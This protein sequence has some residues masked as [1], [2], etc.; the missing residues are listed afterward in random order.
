MVALEVAS[1]RMISYL[2][3][4]AI[5]MTDGI[6]YDWAG[7]SDDWTTPVGQ[8]ESISVACTTGGLDATAKRTGYRTLS[9]SLVANNCSNSRLTAS[10]T[11][12]FTYNDDYFYQ[13]TPLQFY[14]LR[15]TFSN[16]TIRDTI[17]RSFTYSGSLSCDYAYNSV[18]ES[19]KETIETIDG[20]NT[21]VIEVSWGS[22]YDDPDNQFDY[23]NLVR[24]SDGSTGTY[25]VG[26][27]N[28]DFSNVTAREGNQYHTIVNAKYID[29]D[30][31][32]YDPSFVISEHDR[33]ERLALAQNNTVFAR[34]E[35]NLDNGSSSAT[36]STFYSGKTVIRHAVEGDLF[37]DTSSASPV[38]NYYA[39]SGQYSTGN[40]QEVVQF[41]YFAAV[42][43]DTVTDRLS[44]PNYF[45]DIS[46]P[47]DFDN[48]G[49][50]DNTQ[51]YPWV[52]TAFGAAETCLNRLVRFADITVVSQTQSSASGCVPEGGFLLNDDGTV[53]YQD[54][55]LDGVNELFTLDDDGDGV[56]D[57]EDTFPND[58][59]ESVDSDGDGIGDN[60]DPY[61]NNP[62]AFSDSD[63]DGV[64]DNLDAFPFDASESVD[65]D[66][67]G[68]GNN[69]DNDDDN[70]GVID[71]EDAL[72]LDSLE[73]KILNHSL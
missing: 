23:E 38:Y 46:L 59:S 44:S 45:Y 31:G 62:L 43:L 12:E 64:S 4:L 21:F 8:S 18:S 20:A 35:L 29:G 25:T 53:Y 63:G 7:E 22:L 50:R 66:G 65:S 55:N 69:G 30:S 68:V 72:P 56:Q 49:E 67:D 47:V 51:G 52:Y 39:Y 57:S 5:G 37:L 2:G 40:Y 14:P 48:D 17:G 70:D 1:H 19:Y 58:P 15:Y 73:T 6:I 9:G 34:V 32:T 33:S 71:S 16:L 36:E 13:D 60:A 26:Y 61:P 24:N 41:D 27:T 3:S 42:E 54:T 28:C 10:G 11:F